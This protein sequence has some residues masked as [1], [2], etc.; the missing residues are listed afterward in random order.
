MFSELGE[1]LY[2]EMKELAPQTMKAKAIESPNRKYEVW[3]GGST[4][5]KLS[6]LTGMWITIN[7]KLS[8]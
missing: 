1:R 3:R 2:K 5:A 6:S 4:L 8:S 7:S